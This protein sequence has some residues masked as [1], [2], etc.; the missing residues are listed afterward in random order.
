[1]PH[2]IRIPRLGWSMEEGKFIGWLKQPGD[3]V[4]VGEPLF[5]LESEKAVQQIES[6]DSGK[7]H[8]PSDSPAADGVVPVGALLGYLLLPGEAIPDSGQPS[9]HESIIHAQATPSET[10]TD[11]H[12][13]VETGWG[14][15]GNPVASPRARRL[16]AEIGVDWKTLKG[17][18]RDGRICEA[19]VRLAWDLV[20]KESTTKNHILSPRRK[21]IGDRLRLSRERSIPVTLT[22]VAD[23][24]NLVAL[25][26]Q[27]KAAGARVIPSYTDIVACVV[28]LAMKRHPQIAVRW[29]RDHHSLIPI[30]DD[31]FHIG[32][33]VDTPEGLL[34]PVV[35]DVAR[36]SLLAVA[37]ESTEVIAL[38][39]GGRL[40]SEAMQ[41]GA[42]TITN[43]GA[44]GIDAFTPIINEPEI[45]I[46]GL[47]AI[48]RELV[49]LPED[50]TVPRQRITL[51]LTFDHAAIDGVPAAAFLR[52]VAGAIE[53]AAAHLLGG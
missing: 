18:G 15:T 37:Q 30:A 3:Q 52:D 53:N 32:I 47:G 45:A 31:A 11:R 33:A 14:E 22:T 29:D 35:R 17:T 43:L 20:G 9:K 38:A 12:A 8:I 26:E 24:T 39:R 4:K 23:A 49:V 51:S 46:L 25:R 48:R 40:S 36:K 50:R 5:E 6:L 16:A 44:W 42:M 2:E 13:S 41:G 21:A 19:D 1:M 10:I 7:L 28:A 27:F 34:V